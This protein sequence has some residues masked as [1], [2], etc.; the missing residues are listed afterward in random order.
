MVK[1][2]ENR[3]KN[4]SAQLINVRRNRNLSR[5]KRLYNI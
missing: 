2:E 1:I 4:M 3:Y 5:T